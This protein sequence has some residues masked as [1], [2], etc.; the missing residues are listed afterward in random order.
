MKKLLRE[1]EQAKLLNVSPRT[2][3]DY[4]SKKLVPFI[5]LGGLILFDPERVEAALKKFERKEF[6]RK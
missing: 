1:F 4:R 6:V 2:L 5:K 3:R